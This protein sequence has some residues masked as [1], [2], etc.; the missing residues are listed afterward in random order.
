MALSS[1]GFCSMIWS[2]SAM[3]SPFSVALFLKICP[4]SAVWKPC[5]RTSS[6][7]VLVLPEPAGHEIDIFSV[8]VRDL[9]YKM[10]CFISIFLCLDC[11]CNLT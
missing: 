7:I 2:Y 4:T 8:I 10:Y 3:V 5:L 6:S 1:S 11:K 9:I